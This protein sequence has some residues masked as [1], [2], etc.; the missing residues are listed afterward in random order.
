MS[1]F[2]IYNKIKKYYEKLICFSIMNFYK[3]AKIMIIENKIKPLIG[4]TFL[5][6]N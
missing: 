3:T 2:G 6:N 5:K 4:T 1:R